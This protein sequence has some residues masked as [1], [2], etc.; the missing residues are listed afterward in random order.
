[1]ARTAAAEVELLGVDGP[2]AANVLAHLDLDEEPC[3]AP[4]LRIE[5]L[6]A[7]SPARIRDALQAFGYYEPTIEPYL[8]FSDD[9]WHA[10]FMIDPGE[11]VRIRTLHVAVTGEAEHDA[12]FTEAIAQ[13]GLAVGNPLDHGAYDRLRRRLTDLARQRFF[14]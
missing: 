14:A 4:R 12:P 5:Q 1:M 8:L 10:R 6:H 13:A 2:L 7:R 11:P 9:C 3:D